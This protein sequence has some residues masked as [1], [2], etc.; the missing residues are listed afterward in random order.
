MTETPS[1]DDLFDAPLPDLSTELNIMFSRGDEGFERA[2]A[3]EEGL[4]PVFNNVG[5]ASC[6]SGDGRGSND[7]VF[8]RFSRGN[9]LI[10]EEGEPQLQ[11][12]AIPGVSPEVLPEGVDFSPRLPPPVFGVGLIEAI[13]VET[14]VANADEDDADGDGISGRANWVLA[15]EYVS[16]HE[17]GGGAGMQLGRFGRK[18]SVSSLLQ[19]TVAAYHQ[20]I[21][22]TT[23]FAPVEN[24]HPRGS[25]NALGD[26]VADPE[27][28]GSDVQ[29]VV[30]YIRLLTPPAPSDETATVQRGKE[31]FNQVNCA[32]CHTP[33]MTTGLHSIPQLSEKEA[34]LY[35]DLL[36]HDMGPE[37]ADNRPDG[38]A[39]GQE[40]KTAP[41]WGLR[42]AGDFLDNPGYLHDG[43]ASSVEE[44]ILMHGGEAEASKDAFDQ[45]PASDRS[46]LLE[47]VK[48][49]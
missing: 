35:S 4:G 3:I 7:N 17:I 49:R 41:L 11:T 15:A 31:L 42:V 21:G 5:C 9:D 36:V 25:G 8:L 26:A 30:F 14:I 44:A 18:A 46:A 2:F 37:L 16:D 38:M 27:L 10:P 39:T 33:Y 40:W 20:D 24:N 48:S 45:L 22:L 23:D 12:Q 19:Q 6:H 1:D 34:W 29:D 28:S 13:P 47:F 32:S 43:R